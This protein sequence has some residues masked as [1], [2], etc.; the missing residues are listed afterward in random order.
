MLNKI[1]AIC[2]VVI[3]GNAFA[4]KVSS[5]YADLASAAGDKLV[6]GVSVNAVSASSAAIR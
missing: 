4:S 3:F 2:I 5:Q 6:S 1:L